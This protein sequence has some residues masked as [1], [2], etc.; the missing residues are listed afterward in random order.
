MYPEDGQILLQLGKKKMWNKLKAIFAWAKENI[1]Y[2]AG[3]LGLFLAGIAAL[4]FSQ[5]A[6]NKKTIKYIKDSTVHEVKV[7]AAEQK[8]KLIDNKLKATADKELSIREKIEDLENVTL[9]VKK[10][11]TKEELDEFFKKRGLL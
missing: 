1:E 5:N 6:D 8:E 2:I 11:K 7:E 3:A 10:E 9:N 4:V